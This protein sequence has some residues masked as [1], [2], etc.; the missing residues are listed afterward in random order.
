MSS[1]SRLKKSFS[2]HGLIGVDP[3]DYR[4]FEVMVSGK[5]MKSV[6]LGGATLANIAFVLVA[7]SL[8]LPLLSWFAG[9]GIFHFPF[10]SLLQLVLLLPLVIAFHVTW[11]LICEGVIVFFSSYNRL[12]AIEYLLR[13]QR[14][15]E[16]NVYTP[17]D[18]G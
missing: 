10:K 9:G 6:W 2:L 18:G 14:D 12:H 1:D 8:L 16:D 7:S 17:T 5:I 13:Q 15:A 3:A 11:R 4:N